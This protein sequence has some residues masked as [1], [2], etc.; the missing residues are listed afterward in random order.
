MMNLK[1]SFKKDINV[2]FN[3]MEF[4]EVHE[5]DGKEMAIIINDDI[6]KGFSSAS[7]YDYAEGVYVSTKTIYA[8]KEDFKKPLIKGK[9]I[10]LDDNYYY[11]ELV[12][13]IG[14]ILKIVLV[15]NES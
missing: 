12:K 15:A 5:I 7:Q 4:A 3:T 1:E 10:K 13:E 2:F 11:V 14:E 8:K 9:R 6:Q